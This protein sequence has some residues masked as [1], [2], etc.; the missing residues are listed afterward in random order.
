MLCVGYC[1]MYNEIAKKIV[2]FNVKNI[3]KTITGNFLLHILTF[4]KETYL[5]PQTLITLMRYDL[6]GAV[7]KYWNLSDRS[8][9]YK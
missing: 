6:Q 3:S 2:N 1:S 8:L 5:K 7:R 9:H 4:C